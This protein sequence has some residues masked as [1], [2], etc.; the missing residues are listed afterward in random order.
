MTK[1]C[2]TIKKGMLAAEAIALMQKHC[3][4]SLV[5]ID[6]ENRPYAV[7]H[8]HDLLKAGVF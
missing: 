1:N 7:L 8:L 6:E 4:T 2:R 5:I 3:I